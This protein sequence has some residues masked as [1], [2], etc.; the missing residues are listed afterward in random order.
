MT[1][2]VAGARQGNVLRA[3]SAQRPGAGQRQ[4]LEP[5]ERAPRVPAHRLAVVRHHR[6]PADALRGVVH[7]VLA[8]ADELAHLW[9][10]APEVF[11]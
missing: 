6:V 2:W 11:Q 8:P 4:A 1:V 5:R 3:L 10:E 9:T 7:E